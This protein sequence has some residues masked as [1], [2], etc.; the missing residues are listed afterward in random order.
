MWETVWCSG[1]VQ[2]RRRSHDP[3]GWGLELGLNHLAFEMENDLEL[4]EGCHRA[5]QMGVEINATRDHGATHSIYLHDPDGNRVEIYSDVM[6]DWRGWFNQ[7]DRM[8]S[9]PWMPGETPPST[10]RNYDP[11]PE[12]R[13]VADAVFHPLRVTHGVLVAEDFEA[14]LQYYRDVVGLD[15]VRP[16]TSH[17]S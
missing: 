16:P 11:D 10:E 7:G 14:M 13:R 4:V 8:I 2:P 1:L 3:E 9:G 17:T 15:V 12:I 6:K 5:Q